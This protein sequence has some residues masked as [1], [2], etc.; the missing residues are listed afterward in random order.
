MLCVVER[1]N[2]TKMRGGEKAW[3][4]FYGK[5]DRKK[6]KEEKEDRETE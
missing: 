3:P 1:E 2:V 5:R 6:E 4:E